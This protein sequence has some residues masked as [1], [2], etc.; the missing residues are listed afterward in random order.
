MDN[1][2]LGG[3]IQYLVGGSILALAIA[4]FKFVLEVRD[5]L[6]D[7]KHDTDKILKLEKDLQS[8]IDWALKQGFDRRS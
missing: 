2:S 1:F 3:I 6:R 4:T 7:L 5:S 8:L